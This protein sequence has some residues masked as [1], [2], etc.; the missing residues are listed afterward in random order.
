M[1]DEEI[2]ATVPDFMSINV[3][4]KARASTEGN[5]RI[6]Y[7]EASREK[8]DQQ[9]EIVLAKALKESVDHFLKFGVVDLDHKSMPSVAKQYGIENPDEWAIGQPLDVRFDGDV[10][11]VKAKLYQGDTPLAHR[12]N[13]VWDGL[14]KLNPPARYYAS[15][16]GAILGREVRLDPQTKQRVAV[17]TKTRWNNLALSA[18][19]VNQHL[20]AATTAP[21]GTFAKSLGGF[22]LSK[23]L[24]A[25]YGTDSASLAGGAAL[26]KQS[27]DGGIHSYFDF[28]DKLAG[29]M[30]TGTAG[31]NPGGR[32]LVMFAAKQ[33]SI[34]LDQAAEW[35]ERFMRDLK[36]GLNKRSKS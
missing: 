4:M 33:F 12:A 6:I 17:I 25:G 7:V 18:Q 16:G 29:K 14:T 34:P 21:V 28:R 35:V 2:L 10:T 11:F 31:Q 30:R 8:K 32:D 1:T 24:E 9:D 23:G 26:R 22:V 19:P 13:I 3:L 27:L 36:I 15:V 20:S 5:D